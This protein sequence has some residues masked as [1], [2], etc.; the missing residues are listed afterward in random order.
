MVC[1]SGQPVLGCDRWG[2]EHF[3]AGLGWC[4]AAP[5]LLTCTL[6]LMGISGSLDRVGELLVISLKPNLAHDKD[7][8]VPELL[9]P[10][11][12]DAQPRSQELCHKYLTCHGAGSGKLGCSGKRTS[13][14]A[15]PHLLRTTPGLEAKP[16]PCPDQLKALDIF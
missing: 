8:D 6:P 15:N 13:Y 14:G 12:A 7:T 10:N 9:L 16:V 3:L 11:G 5:S 1:P 4:C 2:W